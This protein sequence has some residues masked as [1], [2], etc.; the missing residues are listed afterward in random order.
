[1]TDL[2]ATVPVPPPG[3]E[4]DALMRDAVLVGSMG[5]FMSYLPQTAAR[6]EA[7][8]RLTDQG[9]QVK[10]IER[11]QAEARACAAQ[12]L[13]DGITRLCARMDREEQR[14]EE[15]QRQDAEEAERAEQEE[16]QRTLDALPDPDQPY[17][18]DLKER[19]ASP[20]DQDPEGIIP[21]PEDP[22]GASIDP[23]DVGLEGVTASR[24]VTDPLDLAHPPA[25]NTK[26]V[27]QPVSISLNA[28]D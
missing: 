20:A 8:Q 16:I 13:T 25:P 27:P 22:T 26:Q 5:E 10:E 28:E 17:A 12:I 21:A 14:R 15:Q 2:F 4:R 1:M 19:E 7:E 6:E 3:P 23:D 24:P 9:Q 18:F 11:K